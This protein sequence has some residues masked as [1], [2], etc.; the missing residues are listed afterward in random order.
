MFE[1]FLSPVTAAQSLV[2]TVCKKRKGVLQR[3]M[4]FVV[5]LLT[6]PSCS[7]RQKDGALHLVGTVATLLLKRKM[8]KVRRIFGRLDR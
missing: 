2:H 8:Y 4:A 7:A 5:S 6:N 1:D 3:A